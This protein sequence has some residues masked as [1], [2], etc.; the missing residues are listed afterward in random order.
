MRLAVLWMLALA[1]PAAATVDPGTSGLC[2]MAARRAARTHDVPL[3]VLRA[4]NLALGAINRAMPQLMVAFV[5]APLITFGG[6]A[7]LL[8][9]TPVILSVWLDALMAF[10]QDPVGARP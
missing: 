1:D 5:G 9:A 6:L 3:D 7:L 4:I 10:F 2:D 8:V